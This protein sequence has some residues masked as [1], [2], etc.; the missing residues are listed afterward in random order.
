MVA[1]LYRGSPIA[2]LLFE[3]ETPRPKLLLPQEI[4]VCDHV[5]V[6]LLL[7]T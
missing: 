7:N 3:I 6:E 5:P 2:A 1:P 4:W